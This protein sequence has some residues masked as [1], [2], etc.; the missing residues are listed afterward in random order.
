M[1]IDNYQQINKE[2]KKKCWGVGSTICER[3]IWLLIPI[4]SYL[5]TQGFRVDID[6]KVVTNRREEEAGEGQGIHIM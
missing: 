4:L 2:A 3:F 5:H 1:S 6:A